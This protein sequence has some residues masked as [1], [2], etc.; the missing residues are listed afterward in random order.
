M[1]LFIGEKGEKTMCSGLL[2][3]VADITKFSKTGTGIL[4]PEMRKT[5]ESKFPGFYSKSHPEL[6][7]SGSGTANPVF[8][9]SSGSPSLRQGL[10][11]AMNAGA[12]VYSTVKTRR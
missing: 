10:A 12:G 4:N 8:V 7:K 3:G 5:T 1:A 6:L 2:L 9:S 11:S